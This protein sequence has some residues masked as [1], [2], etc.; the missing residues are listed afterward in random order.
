MDRR[1]PLIEGSLLLV[2]TPF[3]MFP[4]VVPWATILAGCTLLLSWFYARWR[5]GVPWLPNTSA[6]RVLVGWSMMVLVGIAVSADPEYTLPKA[7]NLFLGLAAWRFLATYAD[8][9]SRFL[10]G[11]LAVIGLGL[12]FT[13]VGVA[14]TD[15]QLQI[16][17]VGAL[18]NLLPNT[19]ITLP[20]ASASG[21]HMNALAGTIALFL[22]LTCAFLLHLNRRRLK[23]FVVGLTLVIGL[24][25]T[26]LLL[27]QSR[28]ALVA[29]AGAFLFAS[30]LWSAVATPTPGRTFVR[31]ALGAIALVTALL[32]LIVGPQS[33]IR[34]WSDPPNATL[35]GTLSTITVRQ[36]IWHWAWV[37]IGDFPLTGTGLGTFRVVI[38]RLYP[39][40][41]PLTFDMGHAHNIFLQVALDTGLPGLAFY[42]SIL[43]L[44]L[45]SA[46][47][48]ARGAAELRLMAI[49][50]ASSV[51]AVHLFGVLDAIAPGQKTGL[52][53]WMQLGLIAAAANIAEQNTASA[54]AAPTA[55]HDN[56]TPAPP[57]TPPRT[58]A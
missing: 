38:H 51:V 2:A 43:L 34:I 49:G 26:I 14:T 45:R 52:L 10:L 18:F 58:P 31:V 46:W 41:V 9:N 17:W 36:E 28:G 48:T 21:V 35:I 8:S 50:L 15:W 20:E 19:R 29:I 7:T 24:L 4:T 55:S 42:I 47:R 6:T 12:G 37:A 16:G 3:L 44:A 13:A 5:L 23:W 30:L 11:C 53:F 27:A 57:V 40:M 54:Q 25:L 32:M 33:F 22:P 56:V 39:N 1:W